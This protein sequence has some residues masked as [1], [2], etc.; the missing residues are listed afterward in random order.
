MLGKTVFHYRVFFPALK[1]FP[2]GTSEPDPKKDIFLLFQVYL[3]VVQRDF[4]YAPH[5]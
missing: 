5:I 2:H 4:L 1:R 3:P